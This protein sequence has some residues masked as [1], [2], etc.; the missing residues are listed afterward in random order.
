M[1]APQNIFSGPRPEPGAECI[2]ALFESAGVKIER[3]VSRSHAS[4]EGF[5]HDE[6]D[7]EWVMVLKGDAALRFDDG[8]VVEMKPGDH[9]LIPKHRKHRVERTSEETVWLAVHVKRG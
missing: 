1:S 8:K 4:P 2:L 5:W 7:D 9:L 6:D 3:I